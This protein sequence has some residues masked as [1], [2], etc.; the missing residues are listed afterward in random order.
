HQSSTRTN[1]DQPISKHYDHGPLEKAPLAAVTASGKD[2]QGALAHSDVSAFDE[3]HIGGRAA[4]TELSGQIDLPRG[5]K[6]LD[7]GS[8]LGCPSR[9]FAAER[10]RKIEALDLT[11][12]DVA[13]ASKLQQNVGLAPA[14]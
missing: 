6:V 7:V 8:G 9:Y 14:V 13:V 1:H 2:A 4:T 11:P 10:G 5:A 3:F 12:E